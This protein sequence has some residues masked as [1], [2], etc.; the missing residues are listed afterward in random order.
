MSSGNAASVSG[1]FSPPRTGPWEISH[2]GA[3]NFIVH[4]HCASGTTLVQNEI[5]P[6]DGSRVVSFG[7]GM[8]FWEVRADGNWSLKPR[9]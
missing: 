2:D 6:V 1:L 3:A 8:C 4:L 9:L 5:G 7:E